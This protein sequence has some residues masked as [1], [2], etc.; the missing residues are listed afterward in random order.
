MA[1]A[2]QAGDPRQVGPYR[3][4]RRLGGGGM[5]Q[6]FLG[7]S[8]G[9]RT[10]AVKVVHP[11]LAGDTGFRRRFAAEVEAARAVGGFFTAQ[12]LDADTAAERPWLAT[13]F[14]P[15]P[16]LHEAVVEHGPLPGASVAVLGAGLAEGLAAVHAKALVHRDLKP[17][18]V[19]L[20]GDGPR[21]IDFGIARALEAT[22]FT[23]TRTVLGTAGFMSPEQ[24]RGGT[25]GPPSDVFA[26]GCVLAFAATGRGPF[27]AGRL[28]ALAYRIVHEAPDLSGVPGGL[29]DLVAECLAK[30]PAQRPGL[31]RVLE[32]C[33]A[34][35]PAE[36]HRE[37][38]QWL[39]QALT[40]V[41]A[42]RATLLVTT[43]DPSP[44]I[45]GGHGQDPAEG[46]RRQAPAGSTGHAAP[47]RSPAA[48][49]APPR[50]ADIQP[51]RRWF[52]VGAGMVAFGLVGG[53]AGFAARL[54][55]GMLL[56][57]MLAIAGAVIVIVTGVRRAGHRRRLLAE[58]R[59]GAAQAPRARRHQGTRPDSRDGPGAGAALGPPRAGPRDPGVP[60]RAAGRS[61]GPRTRPTEQGPGKAG[62][63]DPRSVVSPGT[64]WRRTLRRGRSSRTSRSPAPPRCSLR[65][66]PG[67]SPGQR[68]W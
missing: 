28:E 47:D 27:G 13:A 2:L 34:L 10:V 53:V 7:R 30:D 3:L 59:G 43:A 50:P 18:N 52:G 1:G 49:A 56:F 57:A 5:G 17:G 64:S 66:R 26:L 48:Y 16:S 61:S 8:P 6:V 15:G 4:V 19:I 32:T 63:R 21:I 41:V 31:G 45:D 35:A 51:P 55:A 62:P 22:S 68:P 36:P 20:A 24:T 9:G 38:G 33:T 42:D 12:V 65:A 11:E 25:V 67:P 23:Q 58:R 39:P 37:A 29:A 46:P 54:G 14:I 60:A 40:E 44:G